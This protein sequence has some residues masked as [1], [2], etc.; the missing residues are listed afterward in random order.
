VEPDHARS[1]V[2]VVAAAQRLSV[3]YA[4][5]SVI[6]AFDAE[7]IPCILLKGASIAR[8]LYEPEDAR[9]YADG[10]LLV[11]PERFDGAVRVLVKLG[12]QPELDEA[13]MPLWWREHALAS[14]RAQ[15]GT[16]IDLHR[17][18]PG[19]L[20]TG[21]QLWT[22]LSAATEPLPVGDVVATVLT[23][24]GRLVHIALHAA[25]HAGS[26]RDLDVLGRA[27]DRADDQ[28]WRAAA[29][30]ASSIKATAAFQRGLCFLPAGAQLAGRLGLR[31]V[32]VV[33]V[34]LRAEGEPEGLTL[35]RLLSTHDL[36]EQL[37]LVRHKVVPPST[38]MRKWSAMARRGRTGLAIAYVWR[39]LW[40]VSRTPR[41]LRAWNRA[42]R[43]QRVESR[44][45]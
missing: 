39:P 6:R 38:F 4:T 32:P 42:R 18:L 1:I 2:A 24:P 3:D 40:I 41:A 23:Q 19:A 15:D 25:Q 33:D 16:I 35:A 7:G 12:F 14:A 27:I 36:R 26:S 34:E 21:E 13:E 5:A 22:A 9:A 28:A 43:T 44:D 29:S 20:V 30:L 10:D 45:P 37:A 8:W 31:A 17:S 11:P